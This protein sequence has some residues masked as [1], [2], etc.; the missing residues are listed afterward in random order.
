ME[1]A[2][3]EVDFYAG[4]MG[5]TLFE[6]WNRRWRVGESFFFGKIENFERFLRFIRYTLL[7]KYRRLFL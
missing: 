3:T 2:C 5:R 4:N 6:K 1:W 7:I